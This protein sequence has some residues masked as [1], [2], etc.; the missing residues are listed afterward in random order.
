MLLLDLPDEILNI[1]FVDFLQLSKAK[2][3]CTFL[4]KILNFKSEILYIY[5]NEELLNIFEKKNEDTLIKYIRVYDCELDYTISTSRFKKL[6]RIDLINC[7]G[8]RTDNQ[9]K[10]VLLPKTI[11]GIYNKIRSGL[12]DLSYTNGFASIDYSHLNDYRKNKCHNLILCRSH[13]VVFNIIIES[14]EDYDTV[15]S[16]FCYINKF[17]C[18][19]R[20]TNLIRMSHNKY[21]LCMFPL[22][23]LPFEFYDVVLQLNFKANIFIERVYMNHNS[24]FRRFCAQMLLD[25]NGNKCSCNADEIKYEEGICGLYFMPDNEYI[26]EYSFDKLINVKKYEFNEF[27]NQGIFGSINNNGLEKFGLGEFKIISNTPLS[28]H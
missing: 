11:I 18:I 8:V 6:F 28:I 25:K 10:T 7:C 2:K 20:M 12:I 19:T 24:E 23:F 22:N 27:D 1:I 17:P 26:K 15:N 9:L 3:L 16:V 13:D 14:E 5:S 21:L 4:D